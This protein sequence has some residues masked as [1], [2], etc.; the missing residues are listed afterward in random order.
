M[1]TRTHRFNKF[2]DLDFFNLVNAKDQVTVAN[3]FSGE[4]LNDLKIMHLVI[5]P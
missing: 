1:L 5:A 2:V 4:Y 3:G